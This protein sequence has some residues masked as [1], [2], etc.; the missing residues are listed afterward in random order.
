MAPGPIVKETPDGLI[1]IHEI[2]IRSYIDVP[3]YYMYTY[4]SKL[5]S[6]STLLSNLS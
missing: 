6:L 5:I 4:P 3:I 1:A 2:R